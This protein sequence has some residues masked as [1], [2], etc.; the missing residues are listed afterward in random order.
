LLEIAPSVIIPSIRRRIMMT[1]AVVAF[2]GLSAAISTSMT[3]PLG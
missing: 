1:P 2:S 3:L